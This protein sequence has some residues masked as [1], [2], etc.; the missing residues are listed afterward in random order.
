MPGRVDPVVRASPVGSRFQSRLGRPPIL[1]LRQ[2]CPLFSRWSGGIRSLQMPEPREAKPWVIVRFP[3]RASTYVDG[4]GD[5]RR[6]GHPVCPCLHTHLRFRLKD[7]STPRSALGAHSHRVPPLQ[8]LAGKETGMRL[9]FHPLGLA[10]TRPSLEVGS[11][12]AR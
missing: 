8:I 6:Q 3:G 5:T 11:P 2:C 9:A 12:K 7:L 1:I 10:K 4:A